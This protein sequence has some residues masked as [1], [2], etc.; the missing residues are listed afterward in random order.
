MNKFPLKYLLL[1][2][3]TLC[4]FNA[5][6]A[7]VSNSDSSQ[8]LQTIEVKAF[9][10]HRKLTDVSAAVSLI[11]KSQLTRFSNVS[12]LPAL[13]SQPGV[14]ME[15]RSPGSYRINIRGSSL[16]SPFGVRNVKVY[17]ND[18]PYTTPGGDS[19][20]N[21]L[22]FYNFQ[23]LEIIRGPGS[24]LYGAG[25]GGVIL[26]NSENSQWQPSLN[27]DVMGGTYNT[28]NYN[29]HVDAG[30]TGFQNHLN[31]Q[32]QGS[33][34]YRKQT[35]L[36][37]EVFSWDLN[38]KLSDKSLLQAH[39]L[40]SDLFYQTPGGLNQKEFDSI[41]RAARPRVGATQGAEQAK[42]AIYQKTFFTGIH[43]TYRFN[44]HLSQSTS[45]YG[46]FTQLRNPSIFSYSRATE[47][48]TGGRT[49]LQYNKGNLTAH[50]GAE[51]Q[52]GFT[53]VK[54]Y[55]NVN[56]AP[57]SLRTDDD[58]SNRQLFFFGQAAL[59]IKGNWLITGGLSINQL[60]LSVTRL[61]AL[62]V[63]TRNR[64]YSSEIAPRL[65]LLKKIRNGWSVY[66]SVSKGFSPPTNSELLPSSGIISTELEAEKGISYEIGSRGNFSGNRF[67]YD[68]NLF[69]YQL[70]NAIVVRRDN[71]GRDFFVNAGSTSQKG[72]ETYISY[73][74]TPVTAPFFHRSLLWL[75][76]TFYD[77]RYKDFKKGTVDYS[78]KNLPSVP[79]QAFVIGLDVSTKMGG[80][81]NITYTY[82]DR[83][84][85]NDANTDYAGSYQLLGV[86][87]G[88]KKILSQKILLD[89]FA[90]GENLF[91]T[92]Y[93]LGHDL[94]AAGGRYFNTAP[95]R[96]FT[97]GL[98]I[99]YKYR[100]P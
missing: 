14:R 87:I 75:S 79:K 91:D 70:K 76:H 61:S 12:I 8:L 11:P 65:A 19:Y 89:L 37:R 85:L 16:R 73:Q 34:G 64:K 78:G 5:S 67:Y 83:I 62:P 97:A 4:S 49:F 40:Y 22:G 24:S 46:A 84:A 20:F 100:K 86:R 6:F 55:K 82:S 28:Y 52:Q 23:S 92:R 18:I 71:L 95:G 9:E 41:P 54:A 45:L 59:A 15:E 98:S 88:W 7:Q 96:N 72:M 10:V 17:Y 53:N 63:V 1:L 33:D 32:K 26:I 36:K 35:Q 44:D 21:Q 31:Y 48:H 38:S 60:K 74:L 80:Y 3:V 81:T 42:A 25:T 13:N 69:Y 29:L 93:S 30:N 43:Y 68:I 56:G 99:Q 66:A 2:V 39:F 58:V 90:T 77:F 27:L 94:N 47:P 50:V 57:D 51:L